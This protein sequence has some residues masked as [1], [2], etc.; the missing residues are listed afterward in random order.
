MCCEAPPA[1]RTTCTHT[2]PN[3]PS[4][5]FHVQGC[6][7]RIAGTGFVTAEQFAALWDQ[8]HPHAPAEL[9]ARAFA[10][11][12]ACG[13]GQVDYIQWTEGIRLADAPRIAERIRQERLA[14]GAWQ[15]ASAQARCTVHF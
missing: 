1:R 8:L 14:P 9:R 15:S 12:D 7:L 4:L 6:S 3:V 13:S 11:L 5:G 2:L 10:R